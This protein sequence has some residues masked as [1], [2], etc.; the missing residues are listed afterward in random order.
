MK[1]FFLFFSLTFSGL[2]TSHLLLE[3]KNVSPICF[4]SLMSLLVFTLC[5]NHIHAVLFLKRERKRE[6][7]LKQTSEQSRPDQRALPHKAAALRTGN[8]KISSVQGKKCSRAISSNFQVEKSLS[9]P[10]INSA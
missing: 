4:Y 6:T 7:S 10:A 8:N 3:K 9:L 5:H 2:T 1:T